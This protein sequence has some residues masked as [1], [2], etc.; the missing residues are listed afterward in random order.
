MSSTLTTNVICINLDNR[1]ADGYLVSGC[2]GTVAEEKPQ[3]VDGVCVIRQERSSTNRYIYSLIHLDVNTAPGSYHYKCLT[4][5][6]A[7]VLSNEVVTC[8]W[9]VAILGTCREMKI[10]KWVV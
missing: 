10:V 9:C 3:S 1:P 7:T 5:V 2:L 6:Q 4:T 8:K